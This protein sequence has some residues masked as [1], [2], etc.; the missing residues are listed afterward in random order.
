MERQL[1][2][3]CS[4]LKYSQQGHRARGSMQGSF[5]LSTASKMWVLCRQR[6][7]Y[8]QLTAQHHMLGVKVMQYSPCQEGSV[9]AAAARS[10]SVH[11]RSR[12]GKSEWPV[13]VNAMWKGALQVGSLDAAAANM[14][15]DGLPAHL[16]HQ[17]Q[18]SSSPHQA[19]GRRS[20]GRTQKG[21][22]HTGSTT[23]SLPATKQESGSCCR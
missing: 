1:M 9:A 13:A 20:A 7:L 21:T 14:V 3:P 6:A 8:Q 22:W 11:P 18:Q 2:Q 4:G 17:T 15:D 19:P 10:G 5:C 12:R 16:G 23:L